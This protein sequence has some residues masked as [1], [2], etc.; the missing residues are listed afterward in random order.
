MIQTA[1]VGS[2]NGSFDALRDEAASN[3]LNCSLYSLRS[4]RYRRASADNL[5]GSPPPTFQFSQFLCG[6][7]VHIP[8]VLRLAESPFESFF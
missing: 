6:K 1:A 5:K 4:R 7:L 2:E 8:P 3:R